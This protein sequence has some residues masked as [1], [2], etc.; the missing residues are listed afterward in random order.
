MTGAILFETV[1]RRGGTKSQNGVTDFWN[2]V[3]G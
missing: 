1:D 2:D 3:A